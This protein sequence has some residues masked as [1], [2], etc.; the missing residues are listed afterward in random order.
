MPKSSGLGDNLYVGGFNLSTDTSALSRIGGG[1]AA[2]EMTG[3]DK[4]AYERQ[5]ALR[6][7]SIEWT[8]YFNPSAGGAHP[9]LSTLP[10]G[11]TV[12]TYCRGTNL[13]DPAAVCVGRQID[14]APTRGNDGSLS[15]GVVVQS[16]GFGLEWGNQLTAG[17]RTDTVAT[18]GTG[19]DTTAS[20]AFGAQSYLQITAFTGTSVVV[21]V[22]DS[23]DN[24]TFA[25]VTGLAHTS[26]TAAPAFERL[27][28]VNTA[29]I[30]RYLRV[31][32]TGTFSNLT[33]SLVV[34]KNAIAGQ[35]F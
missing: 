23:A 35:V 17:L 25:A 9:I 2:L 14:Y 26:V 4:F 27:A 22:Q 34:V 18:N 20:A 3:I 15:I 8:S 28:T 19:F 10:L 16:D 32:T 11:D 6:G 7:G 12:A 29:T 5:G 1:P 24:V 30:R 31:V 13:G 33:F 21:S